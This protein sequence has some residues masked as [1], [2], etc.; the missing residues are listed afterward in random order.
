[1][2]RVS[3]IGVPNSAGSYAAGQEQAPRALRVAG[4]LDVLVRRGLEVEDLGDLPEQVWRPDPARPLAQNVDDVAESLWALRARLAPVFAERSGRVLVL[5][6][7]CTIALAVVAAL[8]DLGEMPGLRYV[9]RHLDLNTPATTTD[10]AL[11]WMG[12]AHAFALPG[13]VDEVVDV[14]GPRPLLRPSQVVVLGADIDKT[15]EGERR[16]AA[17]V[18]LTVISGQRLAA[19]PVGATRIALDRLPDAA[20]AVHLDVDVLDFTDAPLAEDTAGRNSG[21]GLAALALS[22][23]EAARDPRTVA[24][25]VGELNPTRSRGVPTA[26]PRFLE[27]LVETLA[28]AP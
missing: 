21:P 27:V 11:D 6:G 13:S 4:L 5:G 1:M 28:T 18:D 23:A 20:L 15:T 24:F 19:D 8:R 9:D 2:P 22:L 16:H 7:N 10:G 12:L 17:D 14:L 25:S 26:V 3:V